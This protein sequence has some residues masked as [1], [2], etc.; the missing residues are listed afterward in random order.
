MDKAAW[1]KQLVELQYDTAKKIGFTCACCGR[2]KKP[3]EL[4]TI[5]VYKPRPGEPE[6][7]VT[8]TGPKSGTYILCSTCIELPKD[9]IRFAVLKSLAQHKL[10]E[11]DPIKPPSRR[12]F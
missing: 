6:P 4:G 12:R 9:Q 10:F 7:F 11:P 8:P 2:P 5:K 1:E 3:A